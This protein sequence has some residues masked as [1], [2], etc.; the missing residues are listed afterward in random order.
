MTLRFLRKT[1]IRAA[2][3][4]FLTDHDRLLFKLLLPSPRANVNKIV[5]NF[6]AIPCH[7]PEV[8]MTPRLP[9]SAGSRALGA[10]AGPRPRS[11]APDGM[12]FADLMDEG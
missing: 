8:H 11:G 6:Y 4:N 3:W 7:L 10:V 9:L 12:E 1:A 5:D 2:A